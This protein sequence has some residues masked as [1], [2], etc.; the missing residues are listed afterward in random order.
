[1]LTKNQAHKSEYDAQR[2]YNETDWV[3][4]LATEFYSD[5][6]VHQSLTAES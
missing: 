6:L 4:N 1:M 3:C 5:V 2:G